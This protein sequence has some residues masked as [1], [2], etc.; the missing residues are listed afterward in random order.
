MPNKYKILVQRADRLGDLVLALPV[1]ESIKKTY[2]HYEIDLLTSPI[3]K[4]LV[5]DHSLINK[6]KVIDLSLKG[7][8]WFDSYKKHIEDIKKEKY[9]LYL[10]LWNNP[11][12]AYLGWLARIGLRIGDSSN[13]S[14]KWLYNVPVFQDWEDYTR[15]QIEFNLD[16][17]RPLQIENPEIISKIYLNPKAEKDVQ[18]YAKKMLD[19]NRKTIFILVSTGGTNYAFPQKVLLDFIDLI[20]KTRKFNVILGGKLEDEKS[21]LFKF[22]SDYV[23]NIINE[24]S[25]TELMSFINLADYYI[26][27]DTGPTHIANFLNKPVVFYSPLKPNPPSRWGPVNEYQ[28][29]IREEYHCSHLKAGQCHKDECF[30]YLDSQYLYENFM[31]LVNRVG[32]LK[33]LSPGE[34]TQNRLLHSFRILYFAKNTKDYLN[35][36]EIIEELRERGLKIFIFYTRNKPFLLSLPKIMRLVRKWNIN[37]L[38]GR[39]PD[40]LVSFVRFYL[41]TINQYIKPVYIPVPIH[42]YINFKELI[43]LYKEAFKGQRQ[44]SI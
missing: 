39:L 13:L 15:H 14:L 25:V 9:N 22:Q 30:K 35:V 17:L 1:I 42:K 3:G 38:Q 4:E 23:R 20:E 32:L 27:P 5:T 12:L 10:S 26:G 28:Q 31:D 8:A 2:P 7:R 40:W 16:L 36:K 37:I 11:W 21:E 18:T 29:I 24:T 19:P 43:S 6:V 34:Q 44:Q 41:G 33:S